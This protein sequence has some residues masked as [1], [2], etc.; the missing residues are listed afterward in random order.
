[1]SDAPETTFHPFDERELRERFAVAANGDDD[2]VRELLDAAE[3]GGPSWT[4]LKKAFDEAGAAWTKAREAADPVPLEQTVLP[5]FARWLTYL[6]P[7]YCVRGFSTADLTRL[8]PSLGARLRGPD[9]LLRGPDGVA[10]PGLAPGV[11]ERTSARPGRTRSVGAYVPKD[12]V[13]SFLDAFRAALPEL[14]DA[15]GPQGERPLAVLLS[16]LVEAKLSGQALL[17]ACDALSGDGF[18]P[19]DHRLGQE[20]AGLPPAVVRE[21]AKLY[22]RDAS[23]RL[24]KVAPAPAAPPRPQVLPYSPRSTFEVGQRLAH[25]AFGTGEVTQVLD[26]RR[27]KVRFPDEERTLVQGLPPADGGAPPPG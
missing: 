27:L 16:A 11:A 19:K 1:M 25:K 17:E 26:S 13:R 2:L 15:L 20:E 18:L 21:V 3:V 4:A 23:E 5:T 7:A 24:P 6:R 10:L 12:E 14:K 22:G 8:V 9:A